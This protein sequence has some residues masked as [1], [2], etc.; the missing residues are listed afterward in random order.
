MYHEGKGYRPG[1]RSSNLWNKN[2]IG[3]MDELLHCSPIHIIFCI[4]Q[5]QACICLLEYMVNNI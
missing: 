5:M 1:S 2:R 4:Y 3:V